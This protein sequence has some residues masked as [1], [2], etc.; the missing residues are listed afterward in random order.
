MRV[1]I[2]DSSAQSQGDSLRDTPEGAPVQYLLC[3]HVPFDLSESR[4]L[5]APTDTIRD[6]NITRHYANFFCRN[7]DRLAGIELGALVRVQQP[8]ELSAT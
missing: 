7:S 2:R 1:K 3:A 6:G 8:F 4:S 5:G